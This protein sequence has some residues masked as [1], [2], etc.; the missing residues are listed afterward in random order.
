MPA[1]RLLIAGD[2]P[3]RGDLEQCIRAW[4]L[5]DRVTLAGYLPSADFFRQV[6]GLVLCSRIENLPY[7]ILEAMAW[8]RPVVAT[9]VGG[10]SDLVQDGVSGFLVPDNEAA[11]LGQRLVALA[12]NPARARQ[13]GA[14]GHAV[15]EARFMAAHTAQQHLECYRALAGKPTRP[16]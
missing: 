4:G 16:A 9:D 8:A 15:L 3:L 13:M 1:M 12:G 11:A 10:I 7:C 2:G 6:H 5:Q 14:E